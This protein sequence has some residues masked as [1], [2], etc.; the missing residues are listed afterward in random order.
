MTF[1]D[2]DDDGDDDDDDDDDDGCSRAVRVE[3]KGLVVVVAVRSVLEARNVKG[4]SPLLVATCEH[5]AFLI[6]RCRFYP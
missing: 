5:S 3:N 1:D 2:D 6:W 4:E